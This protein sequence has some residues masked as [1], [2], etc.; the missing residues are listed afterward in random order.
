MARTTRKIR[1]YGQTE[2]TSPRTDRKRRGQV[3]HTWHNLH[4]GNYR[5]AWKH[6]KIYRIF[7]CGSSLLHFTFPFSQALDSWLATFLGVSVGECQFQ[8]SYQKRDARKLRNARA[9]AY[10]QD[11][12][13]LP[14]CT[15]DLART[16]VLNIVENHYCA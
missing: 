6:I 2:R 10:L 4:Y 5:P 11:F 16:S 1:T 7:T 9:V 13:G 8:S 3:Q 15:L 14:T 12:R